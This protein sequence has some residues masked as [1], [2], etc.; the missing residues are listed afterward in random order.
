MERGYMPDVRLVRLHSVWKKAVVSGSASVKRRDS[1]SY[2]RKLRIMETLQSS[3][4]FALSP[5]FD[6]LPLPPGSLMWLTLREAADYLKVNPRTLSLWARQQKVRAHAL[7]G[8]RRKT[9]RFLRSDLD[10]MLLAPSAVL[11]GSIQ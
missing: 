6:P 8:T 10:A 2:E 7:S 4:Q 5:H 11:K 1:N 3:Q 9:L